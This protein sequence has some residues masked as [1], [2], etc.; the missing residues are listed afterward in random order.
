MT[1]TPYQLKSFSTSFPPT[2]RSTKVET[3]QY[4]AQNKMLIR[5]NEWNQC[6]HLSLILYANYFCFDHFDSRSPSAV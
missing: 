3:K 5:D 4:C 6:I 2:S 1:Q